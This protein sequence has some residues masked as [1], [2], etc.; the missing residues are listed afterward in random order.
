MRTGMDRGMDVES[1]GRIPDGSRPW[2][3]EFERL[4]TEPQRLPPPADEY[5][6]P[7]GVLLRLDAGVRLRGGSIERVGSSVEGRPLWAVH[8]GPP[9]PG[10][11][12]L[13]SLLHASEWVSMLANLAL[14]DRL[15]PMDPL[16][17]VTVIPIANPDG[18]ARAMDSAVHQKMRFVR[19]NS[20][21]ID[22]NR[23]FP[24]THRTRGVWAAIPWY[25]PGP[26]PGSEPE[27]AAIIETAR[28][29]EPSICISFHS[30]GRRIFY[31]PGNRREPLPSSARHRE[32][33]VQAG[34]QGAIGYRMGQLGRWS[35]FFRAH[36]TEIDFFAGEGNALSYLIEVSGGGIA[37]WGLRRCFVPFY[38]Y[39]PPRP[40][41]QAD[42]L[43]GALLPLVTGV[44][45]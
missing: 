22:L 2:P 40:Q 3:G 29:I 8:F 6:T 23:N 21:G 45:G 36:G 9:R 38:A 4:R 12:L 27:T 43:A 34:V 13:L 16:P 39:N 26:S 41:D 18:A 10:G 25:R 15:L 14:V 44:A 30:F 11:V 35:P 31:P 28:R 1:Q 37:R 17:T 24:P 5:L 33:L 42:R 20:R 32:T 7:A 19:G